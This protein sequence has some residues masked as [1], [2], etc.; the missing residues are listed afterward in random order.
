[1]DFNK[2]TRHRIISLMEEKGVTQ[3]DVARALGK[4]QSSVCYMLKGRTGAPIRNEYLPILA[5]LF[6]VPADYFVTKESNTDA[7]R[8]GAPPEEDDFNETYTKV[9]NEYEQENA[10]LKARVEEVG[11]QRDYYFNLSNDLAREKQALEGGENLDITTIKELC[12]K[13]LNLSVSL[14][15]A[16][17]DM[18]ETL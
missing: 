6:G 4:S 15:R 11:K 18:L 9:L 17:T 5:Y 1:M 13:Q 10:R 14:M 2:Q 8:L 12:A 3:K 16:V 7:V